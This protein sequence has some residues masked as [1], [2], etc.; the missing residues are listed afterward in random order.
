M[1]SSSELLLLFKLPEQTKSRQWRQVPRAPAPP[2]VRAPPGSRTALAPRLLP[3]PQLS[4]CSIPPQPRPRLRR[5]TSLEL[6]LP[7]KENN[8]IQGGGVGG[9]K[10]ENHLSNHY[11]R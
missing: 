11:F 3:P 7:E 4:V 6:N 9:G 1:E 5:K 8:L 10:G 2:A